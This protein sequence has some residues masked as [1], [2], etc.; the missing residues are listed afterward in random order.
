M[1]NHLPHPKAAK[2][3][4]TKKIVDGPEGAM[5]VEDSDISYEIAD[6]LAQ[7]RAGVDS[8]AGDVSR[9]A[10]SVAQNMDQ[11]SA[12]NFLAEVTRIIDLFRA[13]AWVDV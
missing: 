5:D 2:S 12:A 8:V 7:V 9:Y 13:G 11:Q 4:V 3:I 6:V 10:A 1:L